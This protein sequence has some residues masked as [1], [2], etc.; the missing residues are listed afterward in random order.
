M[1]DW[2]VIDACI[3]ACLDI[4]FSTSRC[5][6]I[7]GGCINSAWQIA[8]HY[9]VFFV[10]L[11]SVHNKD[12]FAAEFEGLQA[13]QESHSIKVPTPITHGATD[14]NAFL[15]TEFMVLD[16]RYS[17][18]SLGEQLAAMHRCTK[19]EHG[20][21][22]DNTIGSTP[23]M[24]KPAHDWVS[25]WR[26]NRLDFQLN[27]AQKNGHNGQLQVL[28]HELSEKLSELFKSY[29][30]QASLLHGDLWSGNVSGCNGQPVIFDPAVYFGDRES[31]LAM[32]ELFGGFS[33]SFYDAYRAAWPLDEGYR[34]RKHLY[35]LY[36]VLNHLNLFGG[37]YYRQS[38]HLL[39]SLQAELK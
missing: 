13:L 26:A 1:Q 4:N 10:K 34:V 29:T 28:G 39:Q 31:D 32:T 2:T 30:P 18:E 11:N 17:A 3:S 22:R 6:S 12:M 5:Q 23:Q 8:D 38:L 21:H 24:N 25:F 35:N 20:W 19:P 33:G 15:V 27:L 36:H 14:Q 7:S 16:N 37:G 9:N